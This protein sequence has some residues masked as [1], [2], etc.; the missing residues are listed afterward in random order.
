MIDSIFHITSR[1]SWSDA[2]KIGVYSDD[3]LKSN[4]FIHCSKLNQIT[5]VAN[6]YFAGQHGLVILVIDL[7]QLIAEVRW[8]AGTDKT[9]ELFPHIYGSVNLEAVG[10]ILDFEPGSG[11]RFFLPTGL[12]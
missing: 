5:Q 3:S 11:G 1:T 10:R 6:T 12:R 4:G 8:E 2:Q 9:S 7:S